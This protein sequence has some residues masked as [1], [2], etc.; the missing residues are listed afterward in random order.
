M[1]MWNLRE[2]IPAFTFSVEAS[3]QDQKWLYR[4]LL[5]VATGTWVVESQTY[6][7]SDH[8][9]L[10]YQYWAPD[11]CSMRFRKDII[12]V[13]GLEPKLINQLINLINLFNWL[14]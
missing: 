14:I 9:L 2:A 12:G 6:L 7:L 13:C 3:M 11:L 5:L 10:C 8:V 1:A 4:A